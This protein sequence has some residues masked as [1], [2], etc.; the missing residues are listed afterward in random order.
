MKAEIEG[1]LVN[2]PAGNAVEGSANGI[3]FVG[4]QGT[5]FGD[6][7][8]TD[9]VAVDVGETLTIPAGASLTVAAA[10]ILV[11][12]GTIAVLGTL[13]GAEGT[14]VCHSHCGGAATC[15]GNAVR[16]VCGAEYGELDPA[17]H[18]HSLRQVEAKPATAEA[19]GNTAYW[20][21]PDCGRCF[22]DEAGTAE[23]SKKSTVV[24]KL[25]DKKDTEADKPAEVEKG[26]VAKK[27]TVVEKPA[28]N[29]AKEASAKQLPTTGFEVP[30]RGAV[31]YDGRDL[32]RLDARALRRNI[33]VVL[34]GEKLFGGSIYDNIAISAPGL[35]LDDAWAAAELAGVA[36]D[37]RAMPMSMH[38]TISEGGRLVAVERACY[39][40]LDDGRHVLDRVF[41]IAFQPFADH[42]HH[43]LHEKRHKVG[44]AG[45][46]HVEALQD[47]GEHV[48]EYTA[49]HAVQVQHI[50]FFHGC[51][52][53]SVMLFDVG[54]IRHKVF[55]R[56]QV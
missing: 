3:V 48:R 21:C 29:A 45:F 23:V 41:A 56:D 8:I 10:G 55:G 27:D 39:A 33:G 46:R 14:I 54:E 51:A 34:Q 7:V 36:D 9:E 16:A 26:T 49:V 20:N 43:A 47:R 11:N 40:G 31:C 2:A 28:A 44:P 30:Q 53:Q 38:T 42:G 19:E 37:I 32:A 15:A 1:S 25:A 12:D 6:A 5:V 17:N 13:N 22:V 24:P 35:S 4:K 50:G 52:K 18:A